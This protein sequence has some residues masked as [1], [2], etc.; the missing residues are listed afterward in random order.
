M[1]ELGIGPKTNAI[2]CN[3]KL[4]LY[5]NIKLTSDILRNI[6]IFISYK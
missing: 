5:M 4:E 1:Y 3:D 6:N 2:I